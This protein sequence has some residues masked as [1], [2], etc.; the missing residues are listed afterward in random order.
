MTEVLAV[1][2]E[3]HMRMLATEA[4][5][6]APAPIRVVHPN[7]DTEAEIHRAGFAIETIDRFDFRPT[8]VDALVAPRI[9]GSARRP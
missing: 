6:G 5:R 1:E 9:V 2:P 8:P 4:A 7:R 3:P